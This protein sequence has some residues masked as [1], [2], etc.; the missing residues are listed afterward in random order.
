M[1]DMASRKA[2]LLVV[3]ALLLAAVYV[4]VTFGS[5]T[6]APNSSATASQ[7]I[8]S[9]STASNATTASWRTIQLT[10]V[11]TGKQFKLSD[12]SGKPVLV[13]QM[14]IWCPLCAQQQAHLQTL[15]QKLGDKVVIVS[16]DIDPKETPQALA[17]YATSNGRI[18]LWSKDPGVFLN[19]FQ[20]SPPETPVLV[21]AP[22]G[23][24]KLF[25]GQITT[26]SEFLQ[27]LQTLGVT[28]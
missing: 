11:L 8:S 16:V 20:L 24:F 2:T 28:A 18:W 9:K 3:V 25:S 27:Y 6:G 5:R 7:T 10:D 19:F 17:N 21:I 22:D 15:K 13:E 26:S 23:T 1:V 4:S 14:A 12:F